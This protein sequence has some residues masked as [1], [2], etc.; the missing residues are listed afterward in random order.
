[1]NVLLMSGDRELAERLERALAGSGGALTAEARLDAGLRM[2]AERA[3]GA[4]IV[5]D[6]LFEDPAAFSVLDDIRQRAG[7]ARRAVLLSNRPAADALHRLAKECL[8]DG[9]TVVPPGRSVGQVAAILG[10]MLSG[11]RDAGETGKNGLIQFLGT[12]PNIGT[13]VAAFAAA[14]AMAERTSRAVGLLCLNLKSDKLHRYLGEADPGPAL[15]GLR[16]E[17]KAG[18]LTPERLLSQCRRLRR[19]PNLHILHGN[20]HREQADYYAVE[21]LDRLFQAAGAAFD[22][23]VADTS[24][25]WDNAGTVSA[26]LHAGQRIL[27]T[28]PQA[29]C[30]REDFARWCGA[31]SPVFGLKP[32]DFDLLVTQTDDR[33]PASA[34]TMAREMGLPRIGEI[35]RCPELDRHLEAGRLAE[36]AAGKSGGAKDAARLGEALLTL[37]DEPMRAA[38]RR[39]PFSWRGILRGGRGIGYAGK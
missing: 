35:R 19:W 26:M 23:C 34:R 38:D 29:A 25:Y 4:V 1:M 18:A 39:R 13:T 27:V 20:L 33:S 3:Y 15:D 8:A 21:E 17:L 30:Y 36:W 32:S 22:L 5:S 37:R 16:P 2:L 11:A 12:T 7:G 31:L 14:A 9:W 24:A 28:T 10:A 6:R